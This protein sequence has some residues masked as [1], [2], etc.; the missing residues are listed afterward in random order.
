M[1]N[2]IGREVPFSGQ[3]SIALPGLS[4]FLGKIRPEAQRKV[5]IFFKTAQRP[6]LY[7][8]VTGRAIPLPT[9]KGTS[10]AV[11]PPYPRVG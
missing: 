8:T 4:R 6:D 2:I 11:K 10:V 1:I 3:K 7:K 9:E 5:E